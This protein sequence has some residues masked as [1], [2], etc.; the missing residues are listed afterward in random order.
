MHFML[1][2]SISMTIRNYGFFDSLRNQASFF[3]HLLWGGA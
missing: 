3:G 1:Q 2:F